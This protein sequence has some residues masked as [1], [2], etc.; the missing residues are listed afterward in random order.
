MYPDI[1]TENIMHHTALTIPGRQTA[2]IT[3]TFIDLAT[4]YKI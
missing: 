1:L 2:P 4:I 3:L